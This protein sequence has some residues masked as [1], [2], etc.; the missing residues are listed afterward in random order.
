MK[1]SYILTEQEYNDLLSSE[2]NIFLEHRVRELEEELSK[3]K[4]YKRNMELDSDR[5]AEAVTKPTSDVL[6]PFEI[7]SNIL[8]IT[9]IEY[10][11]TLFN[12][13]N[14]TTLTVGDNNLYNYL[15]TLATSLNLDLCWSTVQELKRYRVSL[16]KQSLYK[17]T[18]VKGIVQ[19]TKI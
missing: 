15:L 17:P 18:K 7:Q 11:I 9:D 4:I 3:Y 16:Q 13:T 19:L 2:P 6:Y 8:H 14:S 10:F 1:P 12:S 5:L